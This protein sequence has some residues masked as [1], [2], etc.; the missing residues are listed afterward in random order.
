MEQIGSDALM[1]RA[2]EGLAHQMS[3]IPGGA[4]V[5]MLIGPGNN[6]GDA[7]FA[8]THLLRRSVA[9]DL[10]ALD[11]QKVHT[12]GW[13]AALA[14]GAGVITEHNVRQYAG[15]YEWVVDALFGIGARAPLRDLAAELADA[16]AG[17]RI[18]AVDVP[19]GID[20]D[21]GTVPG[22]AVQARRT[23]TFGTYKPG[24]LLSPAA[25]CAG[26]DV[27]E[28][29][30]IGLADQLGP[31]Q[32]EAIEPDD[33]AMLAGRLFA[34][35]VIHKYTRGVVGVAA[36]S[37]EFAG[38]AHLAIAGAQAGP[39]GMIRFLG[40]A[41]LSHRVV[42][43]AP[44]VVAG[45]GQVQAWVTGSGGGRDAAET[46]RSVLDDGVPT[47]IDADALNA[48][49]ET[50]GA[51]AV[52]T[53]HA[54]E[55]ARMLDVARDA[56]ESDPLTYGWAA[57][58][59]W[60]STVLLKGKRTCVFTPGEPVRVNL[61][62][63]PWLATAGAGDVLAGFIGSLLAAGVPPHDAASIGAYLHGA[64]AVHANPGGP[65]VAHEVADFLPRVTAGFLDGTLENVRRWTT[66]SV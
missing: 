24:L 55:L 46:L 31:P 41:E 26:T 22:P 36:G 61:S 17:A 18:L 16:V 10:C 56:V 12:S 53:P 48:L 60:N 62:G 49:P 65:V 45:R 9:V 51:P 7:L 8:A 50:F 42:D 4:R 63:T 21:G 3:D 43:R 38:A 32:F 28:L 11:P 39:A 59:R 34:S 23:V 2:A 33:G 30:D 27:A 6:G 13:Q 40:D 14:A 19:S 66:A 1:Q 5:L 15:E 37:D 20:V 44:E 25:E 64:A 52:L 54:G 47:V 57:A 58:E 35:N 29:V